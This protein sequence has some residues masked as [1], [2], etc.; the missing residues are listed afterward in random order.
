MFALQFSA[1]RVFALA[2]VLGVCGPAYSGPIPSGEWLQFPFRDVGTPAKGCDPG[3]PTGDFCIPSS[4]T[5]ASALD[6]PPWTFTSVLPIVLTITDAFAATERF[7]ILDF[8]I[9]IG[10][11]SVPTLSVNCGDDPS[12]CLSTPGMSTALLRLA[13]GDHSLTLI[14]TLSDGGGSGFMRVDAVPEPATN[15]LI[16]FGLLSLA[17]TLCRTGVRK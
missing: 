7:S 13:P 10:E 4:G 16:A 6:T 12:V 17:W 9:S 5:P 2:A 8:N 15:S 14:P 3:D 1:G 11:T